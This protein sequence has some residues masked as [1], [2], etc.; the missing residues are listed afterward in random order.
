MLNVHIF[1]T[2]TTKNNLKMQFSNAP[3]KKNSKKNL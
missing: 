3:V 1:Q 2:F